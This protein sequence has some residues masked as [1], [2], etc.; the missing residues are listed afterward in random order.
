MTKDITLKTK[1]TVLSPLFSGLTTIPVLRKVI[2]AKQIHIAAD[3]K[4][5]TNNGTC[6]YPPPYLDSLKS[7][8]IIVPSVLV[9][10]QVVLISCTAI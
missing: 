4:P 10:Q 9:M 2:T 8:L 5:T 6:I 7:V 1:I 3:I